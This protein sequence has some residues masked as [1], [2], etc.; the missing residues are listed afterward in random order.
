MIS[1]APLCVDKKGWDFHFILQ[2]TLLLPEMGGESAERERRNSFR[3][4]EATNSSINNGLILTRH[5]AAVF[6]ETLNFQFY[7]TAHTPTMALIHVRPQ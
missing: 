2:H 7:S 5:S 3:K 1:H 4:N 6:C